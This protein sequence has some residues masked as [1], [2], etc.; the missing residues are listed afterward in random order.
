M[1]SILNLQTVPSRQSTCCT[2]NKRSSHIF[3][4]VENSRDHENAQ[5]FISWMCLCKPLCFC[6]PIHLEKV[7]Q[8]PQCNPTPLFNYREL[9][10]ITPNISINTSLAVKGALTHCLHN[11]KWPPGAQNG[12]W[13]LNQNNA[14]LM[15]LP[16]DC[17]NG[18]QLQ[19]Q[20]VH[21][22]ISAESTYCTQT[23]RMI[24]D[25]ASIENRKC[26]AVFGKLGRVYKIFFELFTL[27]SKKSSIIQILSHF[28]PVLITR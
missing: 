13:G 19:R 4:N 10:Y 17:L 6:F 23:S 21:A 1:D 8:H 14:P 27:R 15:S 5:H 7:M 28:L 25:G 26:I 11:P 16:L 20:T 18:N 12:Q 22:K 9:D 24:S 2:C 3:Q